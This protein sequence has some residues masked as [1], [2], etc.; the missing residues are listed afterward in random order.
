VTGDSLGRVVIITAVFGGRDIPRTVPRVD[1]DDCVIITDRIV[2]A[3]GWRVDLVPKPADFRREAR[4]IKT[5]A[6]DLIQADT[7]LWIDGRVTV[8]DQPLRPLLERA[9]ASAEIAAYPHPWRD[10]AYDEAHECARLKRAPADALS[11]QAAAY[12]AAGL[13]AHWGLRN[14]MVL[15]RRNTPAMREFGRDWWREIETHT[16][17]DQVSL[18]YL[19]WRSGLQ[20][21]TM[22]PDLYAAHGKAHFVRGMH[23]RRGI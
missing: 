23:A 22:G 10:C 15:A 9:L 2:K 17:R 18:P 7:V 20:C 1:V 11:R 21:P 14:T 6:L 3:K 8:R 13:P 19:L 12:R 4:R 16:V 5:L